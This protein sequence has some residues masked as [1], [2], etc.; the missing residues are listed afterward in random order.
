[1]ARFFNEN[2]FHSFF[3]R[4]FPVKTNRKRNGTARKRNETKRKT[5]KTKRKK[6]NH[7]NLSGARRGTITS[8]VHCTITISPKAN[9][10]NRS[11]LDCAAR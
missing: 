9:Q 4:S 8:G 7:R 11:V 10:S 3:F 2:E 1:M 6:K 5:P